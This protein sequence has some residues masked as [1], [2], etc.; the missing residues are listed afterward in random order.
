MLDLVRRHSPSPLDPTFDLSPWAASMDLAVRTG[1]VYSTS[2]SI[3]PADQANA[4]GQ[5]YPRPG[6]ARMTDARCYSATDMFAAGFQDHQIGPVLGVHDNTGA[7]G[8]NVW[9]HELLRRLMDRPAPPD[10]PFVA[11]PFAA[12]PAN[13]GLRVAVRRTVRVGDRSGTPVEDLGV[14]P[15]ERHAMTRRDLSRATPI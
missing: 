11:N 2:H 4:V 9:T 14:V 5:R 7:G 8:A 6:R 1:S 15:D 10:S 12:L 13:M 3:T